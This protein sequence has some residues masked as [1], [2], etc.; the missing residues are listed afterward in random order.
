MIGGGKI[1]VQRSRSQE[2]ERFSEYRGGAHLP[3]EKTGRGPGSCSLGEPPKE[4]HKIRTTHC[5]GSSLSSET[6]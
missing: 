4:K 1:G 3:E 5:Q 6:P 2:K